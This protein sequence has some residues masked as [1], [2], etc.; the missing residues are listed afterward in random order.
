MKRHVL[1]LLL[2]PVAVAAAPS[3]AQADVLISALPKTVACGR[4]I[5]VGVWYQAASGG[6][7]WA[8]IS[9]REDGHV[10]AAKTVEATTSWRY[11]TYRGDCGSRLVVKYATAG[12]SETYHVRV[13]HD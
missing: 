5:K 6:P 12:G 10:V 2:A 13:G 1:L 7:R 8:R 3:L 4:P 11:W 9:I